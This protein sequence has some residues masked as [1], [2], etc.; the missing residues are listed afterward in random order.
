MS[1]LFSCFLSVSSSNKSHEEDDGDDDDDND[2]DDVVDV[3]VSLF[4][5]LHMISKTLN[6]S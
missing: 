5:V 6:E 3:E 1:F 4:I 2:D